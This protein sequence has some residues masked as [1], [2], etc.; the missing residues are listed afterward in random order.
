MPGFTVSSLKSVTVYE[1]I[2]GATIQAGGSVTIKKGCINSTISSH[3]DV[4]V[5]FCENSK[6]TCD[7]DLKG[8]AFSTCDVY[9][10]G[11]F[12][13]QGKRGIIM[14]G[15]YTCL[16]NLLA[17]SIGSKSYL[18]TSLTVGDNAIMLE[19]MSEC[20]KKL[21]DFDFKILRCTQAVEFLT[22]KKK[23][24]PLPPDKEEMLSNSIKAKIILGMERKK[25]EQRIENIKVYLENKQNLSITVK[26]ELYP[27]TKI[28]INDL[29]FQV[30][31]KYQFCRIY[32]GE[33]GIKTE[34]L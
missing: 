33:D 6:I 15:K 22:A 31:D 9:A 10:G 25:V 12:Q 13:V 17:N 24:S 3:G 20:E 26:K 7:G 18:P 27:G 32:L 34:T 16:K 29:V 23:E 5:D 19:E 28:I 8:D 21:K 4:N 2:T 14:G 11:E 30:N 1:N